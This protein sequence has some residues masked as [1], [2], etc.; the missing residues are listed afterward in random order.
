MRK[1]VLIFL[2][3]LGLAAVLGLGFLSHAPNRLVSGQSLTLATVASASPLWP[4]LPLAAGVLLLCAAGEPENN[5]LR[6]IKPALELL[7]AGTL[8][9]ALVWLAGLGATQLARNAA[10]AARTSLG[11]GF[12]LLLA[13]CA[14][15]MGNAMRR[16]ALAPAVYALTLALVVLAMLP[17]LGWMLGSGRLDDLSLLKEYANRQDVFHS[18][19]LRHLQ[20]VLATVLP[21]LLI[22]VPL[23]LAAAR[24]HPLAQPLFALL[25]LVQTVPS[26]AL[27]ALLIA[28][29]SW[30]AATWPALGGWGI[31][32]IGMA[33]AVLALVLYSLLP[34]ARSTQTGL[35]QVSAAVL[36][37]ARGMG[38]TQ[39]QIFWRV[40][41]PLALPVLLSG[42]RV[43]VVQTVGLAVVAA[44]I[45][46]GG[47]GA[48]VFQGLLSSAADLVLLGVLPV[49]ALALL[50]DALFKLLG[51]VARAVPA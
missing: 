14:L 10:A 43:C 39:R 50:A 18:A 15:I 44:L 46:A 8:L 37:S 7:A 49:L 38:L 11:A 28:P 25:N 17:P 12:W 35:Q 6:F 24:R 27:F 31:G 9:L 23:G 5:M 34:V 1:P 51:H 42:V 16:M 4:V 32:G 20:L 19:L 3:I 41:L 40:E 26:L 47:L 48:L 13:V 33:P 36:E 2:L 29:L 30:L 21:A 45:G 22:A